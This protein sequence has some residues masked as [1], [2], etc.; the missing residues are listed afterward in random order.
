HGHTN[1]NRPGKI[2]SMGKS[3]KFF[4]LTEENKEGFGSAKK[5]SKER[6]EIVKAYL[7]EQGIDPDR[8]ETKGWG[9]KRMIHEKLGHRARHNVRVEIEILE[10]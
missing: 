1:G 9:G 2:I 7:V 3:D 4:A 8:M 6:A 10:E 5:L